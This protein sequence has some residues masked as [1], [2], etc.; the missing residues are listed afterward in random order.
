MAKKG[1]ENTKKTKT[2]TKKD[3]TK[4]KNTKKEKVVKEEQAKKE[5]KKE[6]V[7]EEAKKETVKKIVTEKEAKS[8]K[9]PANEKLAKERKKQHNRENTLEFIKSLDKTIYGIVGL[10]AGILVTFIIA[11]IVWPDRIATL[12][13]GTQ[14]VATIDGNIITADDL[15][16]EMKEYYSISQILNDID[17]IILGDLYPEDDEMT[18]YAEQQAEYYLNLYE[19][20]YGYTEEEFL[21]A[22][23]F[24]SYND[25]LDYLKLDYRRNK[26][27][28]DYIKDN[29][30]DKEIETYYNDNVYGSINCQHI[31][32]ATSDDVSDDDAKAL[33]QE[34]IDKLNNGTSWEDVQEE[35]KD[36]ITFEDLGYQAWNASLEST[37]LDALKNLKDNSYSSEPVETSYGYHVIYRLDQKETPTL[38]D[39]KED[40]IS[41]IVEEKQSDDSDISTKALISLREEKGLTFSDTVIENKYK[42]YIKQYN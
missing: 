21:E 6:A 20:Y 16:E 32:V 30:T 24:G 8:G 38:E 3:N 9:K 22:N 31:L 11:L 18:E 2:T 33:A 41:E 40:I 1:Q 37:F 29:L 7:K 15:Y 25:F 34:I 17:T 13:D 36:D 4:T 39:A 5:N 42:S 19:S 23:G 35:Y 28:E 10:I 12:E 27:T 14:P 26:Y